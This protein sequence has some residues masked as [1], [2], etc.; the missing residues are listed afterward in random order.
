MNFIS[1]I[2][3]QFMLLNTTLM[4]ISASTIHANLTQETRSNM[5]EI[6]TGFNNNKYLVLTIAATVVLL[7]ALLGYI[8]NGSDTA[9]ELPDDRI[10]ELR[11]YINEYKTK[12]SIPG[13][14]R[15]NDVI[16]KK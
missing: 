3:F 14:Q 7:A 15:N 2:V 16:I 4:Q 10:Q 13:I 11:N 6:L 1:I 12:G 9:F 5:H 8:L